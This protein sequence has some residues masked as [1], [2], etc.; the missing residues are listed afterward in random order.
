MDIPESPVFNGIELMD[1]RYFNNNKR[2]IPVVCNMALKV[3]RNPNVELLAKHIKIHGYINGEMDARAKYMETI[4]GATIM[5]IKNNGAAIVS[6]MAL[7]KGATDPVAGK[8][9]VNMLNDLLQ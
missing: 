7:E 8:L 1:L 5:K 3:S 9:L 6:T 2:E 4:Q